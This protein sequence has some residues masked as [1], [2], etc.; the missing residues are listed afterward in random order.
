M[1]VCVFTYPYIYLSAHASTCLLLQPDFNKTVTVLESPS[2]NLLA[3]PD[4][5]GYFAY[6]P[7]VQSL[8]I[9]DVGP[10]GS[11]I[12]LTL[13]WIDLGTQNPLIHDYTLLNVSNG[14]FLLIG[15]GG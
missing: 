5:T 6:Q 4:Q 3:P 2:G 1:C 10:V 13:N 9:L 7:M 8:W 11:K 14:D 15:A 12:D